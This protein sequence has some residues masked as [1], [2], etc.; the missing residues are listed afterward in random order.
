VVSA[1]EYCCAHH[2]TRRPNK[3]WRSTSI[4]IYDAEEEKVSGHRT[5]KMVLLFVISFSKYIYLG[6][7]SEVWQNLSLE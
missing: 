4:L 1:N 3:L 6:F 5:T 2:V 7:G